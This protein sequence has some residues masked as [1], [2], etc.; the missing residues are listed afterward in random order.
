[1]LFASIVAG[2]SA[3]MLNLFT[4]VVVVVSLIT[5]CCS[6]WYIPGKSI[7]FPL[8]CTFF[9]A[10]ANVVGFS[11]VPALATV[12]SG[13]THIPSITGKLFSTVFSIAK[14]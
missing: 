9:S 3:I 7:M 14:R 10:S 11:N 12:A 2:D 13:L 5:I 4:P 6:A 1:M 8:F